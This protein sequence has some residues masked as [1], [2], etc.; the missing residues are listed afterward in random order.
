MKSKLIL[1]ATAVMLVATSAQAGFLTPE[2]Q[3]CTSSRPHGIFKPPDWWLGNCD[4]AA[5]RKK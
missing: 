1:L 2:S 3:R 5:N 4:V